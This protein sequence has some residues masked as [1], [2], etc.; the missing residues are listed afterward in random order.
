MAG[1]HKQKMLRF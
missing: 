1:V